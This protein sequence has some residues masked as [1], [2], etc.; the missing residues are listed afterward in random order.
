[1]DAKQAAEKLEVSPSMIYALVAEGRLRHERIGRRGR[2]GKIIIRDEH[3]E[4]FRAEIRA[5]LDN[6]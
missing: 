2:R 1:M 6:D 5:E 4:A 3:I